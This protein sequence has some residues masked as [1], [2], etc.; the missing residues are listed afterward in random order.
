M[1]MSRGIDFRG[2]DTGIPLRLKPLSNLPGKAFGVH[3]DR[4]LIWRGV[5]FVSAFMTE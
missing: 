5:R 3:F 2:K 4:F 1:T